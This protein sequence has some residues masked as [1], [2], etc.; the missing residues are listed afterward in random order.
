MS[1]FYRGK[2]LR[3]ISPE[4]PTKCCAKEVPVIL[5]L[6]YRVVLAFKSMDKYLV[7]D[8]SNESY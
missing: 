4:I 1:D 7:C 5:F 8:H 3:K 2:D 6:L